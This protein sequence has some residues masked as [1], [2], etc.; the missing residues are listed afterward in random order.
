MSGP[1]ED[2]FVSGLTPLDRIY[3]K[4]LDDA[5]ENVRKMFAVSCKLHAD[6]RAR[7]AEESKIPPL[8]N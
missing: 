2:A 8:R 1:D 6:A 4:A 7:D 3:Y 5:E